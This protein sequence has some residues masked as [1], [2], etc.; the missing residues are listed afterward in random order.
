MLPIAIGYLVQDADERGGSAGAEEAYFDAE[1][2][3]GGDVG[4]V[5]SVRSAIR[6]SRADDAGALANFEMQENTG[7]QIR[8][9]D[10]FV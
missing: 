9:S 3:L 1:K 2:R 10:A 7:A 6:N 8:T 5:V 4:V